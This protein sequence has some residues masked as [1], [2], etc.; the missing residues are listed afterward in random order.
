MASQAARI[1]SNSVFA[2]LTQAIRF[3]TNFF[4]FVGVARWYGVESFGQFTTAHSISTVFLLFAD[5]GFDT[6]LATEVSRRREQAG[7]LCRKYFSLKILF[8]SV[9]TLTMMLVPAFQSMSPPTKL[10]VTTFSLYVLLASTNNFL[11][12]LFK[13][14]EQFNHETRISFYINLVLLATIAA[15]GFLHAPLYTIALAFVATRI[16][17]VI[18]G[19][20]VANRLLRENAFRPDFS[21]WREVWQNVL[22]FGS[23]ALF[24]NL[25]FVLDT[26]MLSYVR[27]DREVGIYQAAFKLMVLVLIIPDI[28]INTMLPVLSRLHRDRQ[29]QW[30]D[31]GRLLNK[32]LFLLSLPVSLVLFVYADQVINIVYGRNSFG[33]AVPILRLFSLVVFVRYVVEGY[34]LMLTTSQRQKRRTSIVF[35]GT[36]VNVLLNVYFIPRQGAWGAALVSLAT[37]L[38]VGCGYVVASQMPFIRWTFDRRNAALI[39][40]SLILCVVL[41]NVRT[42]S[43]WFSGPIVLGLYALALYYIGYS[44]HEWDM[45]LSRERRVVIA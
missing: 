32:T 20:P 25:F 26:W 42:I 22:V 6:L 8:A 18:I 17:G 33:D 23:H 39:G 24:G 37:N 43:L 11:F 16:L 3:L 14:F 10:L 7:E 1:R 9:A 35:F 38:F 4:V 21:G 40:L 15:L 27:G 41:W 44:R 34:A 5:F 31:I 19:L 2:F 12:A 45:I 36:L 29:S 30:L 28:A 13:G